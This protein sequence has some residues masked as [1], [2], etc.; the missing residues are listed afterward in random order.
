MTTLYNPQHTQQSPTTV[1]TIAFVIV[2]YLRK[3]IV[4]LFSDIHDYNREPKHLA[5]CRVF[6]SITC[7]KNKN[8]IWEE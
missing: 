8:Y 1:K 6:Q 5:I 2:Y 7:M 4:V 3:D